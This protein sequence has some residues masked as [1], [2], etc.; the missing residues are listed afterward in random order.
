MTDE[1]AAR[2]YG[3]GWRSP[4]TM[5]KGDLVRVLSVRGVESD[6]W[7]PADAEPFGEG[8]NGPLRVKARAYAYKSTL[9]A[10]CWRPRKED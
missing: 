10:V 9:S 5:P 3:P 7:R 4:L 1:E 2:A 8:R 6:A